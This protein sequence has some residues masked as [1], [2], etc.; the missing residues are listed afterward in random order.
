MFSLEWQ[1]FVPTKVNVR[2]NTASASIF[3]GTV[4]LKLAKAFLKAVFL[5]HKKD[6]STMDPVLFALCGIKS[7]ASSLIPIPAYKSSVPVH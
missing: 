6:I 5:T 4:T 7:G 3:A 1:S 2:Q